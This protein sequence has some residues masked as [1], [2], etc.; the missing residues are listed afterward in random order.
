MD[1][2]GWLKN[3]T[4][5]HSQFTNGSAGSVGNMV[6]LPI[7]SQYRGPAPKSTDETDIID[8]AL[9]YFKANVFF[10]TYEIKSEADRVLIYLTL[11]ISECLKKLQ[12]CSSK[13]QGVQDMKA[14]AISKFDIPGEAGFPLN[15]VYAKPSSPSEAGKNFNLIS[16]DDRLEYIQQFVDEL[17]TL[18][19]HETN[20]KAAEKLKCSSPSEHSR[21][22]KWVQV[23]KKE[24]CVFLALLL[25]QEI[26][27]KPRQQWYWSKNK[28]TPIFGEVM[29][30]IW[31]L[32]MT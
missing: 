21:L 19:V 18:V 31:F 20:L 9:Y 29:P 10:R 15:P 4:A 26:V 22:K 12:K 5:Y 11:Y 8:E 1:I 13:N 24:M 32:I 25:L 17:I 6:I 3:C 7:K 30:G 14:L 28:F 16:P 23:T 2:E 27:H